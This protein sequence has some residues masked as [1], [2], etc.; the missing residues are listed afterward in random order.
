MR[1][2][3]PKWFDAGMAW[4]ILIGMVGAVG[5]MFAIANDCRY[6]EVCN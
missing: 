2:R 1:K 5:I 6:E 3:T 4:A